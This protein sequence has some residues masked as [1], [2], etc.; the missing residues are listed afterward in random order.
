MNDIFLNKSIDDHHV[1]YTKHPMEK[2]QHFL[3]KHH[4]HDHEFEKRIAETFESLNSIH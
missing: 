1:A 4:H 2:L 3:H